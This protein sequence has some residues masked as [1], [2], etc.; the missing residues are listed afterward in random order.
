MF[1]LRFLELY[2]CTICDQAPIN[3]PTE[4]D[5]MKY[6]IPVFLLVTQLKY[7]NTMNLSD[8]SAMLS[9]KTRHTTIDADH[10]TAKTDQPISADEAS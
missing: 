7:P 4:D 8:D 9:R 3:T 2:M 5:H 1:K 10:I 6:S